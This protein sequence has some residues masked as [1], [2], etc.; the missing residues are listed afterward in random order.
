[1]RLK[2]VAYAPGDHIS[3]QNTKGEEMYFICRGPVDVLDVQMLKGHPGGLRK[4]AT[5]SRHPS[6]RSAS[7][8][9]PPPPT[10]RACMAY[11]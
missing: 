5:T 6:C 8:S 9:I 4:T 3:R 1:M 10:S 11:A 2:P 7:G